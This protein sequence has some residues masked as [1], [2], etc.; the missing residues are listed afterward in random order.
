MLKNTAPAHRATV[1]VDDRRAVFVAAQARKGRAVAEV[2]HEVFI[3]NML[4]DRLGWPRREPAP[5]GLKKAAREMASQLVARDKK[6]ADEQ[7]ARD[8]AVAQDIADQG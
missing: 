7:A 3:R 8:A 6:I 4:K 1:T 2:P 5:E